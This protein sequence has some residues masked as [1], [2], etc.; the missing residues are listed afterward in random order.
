[1]KKIEKGDVVK[2][3]KREISDTKNNPDIYLYQVIDFAMHTETEESLVIYKALY[4]DKKCYA[5]PETDFYSKVDRE[6]YPQITQKYRF[7]K[8]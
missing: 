5:R 6:K 2:H 4:D 7:E 3:F 8:I 1:M